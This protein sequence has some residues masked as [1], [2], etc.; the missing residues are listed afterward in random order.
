MLTLR[1]SSWTCRYLATKRLLELAGVVTVTPE[2]ISCA[3]AGRYV[4]NHPS[5]LTLG[6]KAIC[7][8]TTD[9]DSG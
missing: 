8:E 1:S 5:T 6:D 2:Y 3:F 7:S 4:L 9:H